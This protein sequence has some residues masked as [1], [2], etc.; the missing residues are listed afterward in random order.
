MT[1]PAGLSSLELQGG[2]DMNSALE[3][4]DSEVASVHRMGDTLCVRFS[5]AYV[6]RSQGRPGFDA[7]AGY[8]QSLELRFQ[9]AEWSGDLPSCLGR[10]SDGR[11]RDGDDTLSLVPLPYRSRGPVAAE[12]VFQNGEV[13]SVR[14]ASAALRFT[15]DPRFV[16][17][18]A[19]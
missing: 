6:H 14:S 12:L 4:H 18:H 13:L 15:G 9:Q 19:C 3:F 17:S 10:L 8:A 7:G 5:A 2:I 16:E 1:A 11:L